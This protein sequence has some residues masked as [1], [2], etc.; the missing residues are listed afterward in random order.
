MCAIIYRVCSPTCELNRVELISPGLYGNYINDP[1]RQLSNIIEEREVPR[2]LH[3][4]QAQL[5]RDNSHNRRSSL[6]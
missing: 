3:D 6:N 1:L 5:S 4:T 2:W